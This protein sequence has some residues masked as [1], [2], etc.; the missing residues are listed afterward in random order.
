MRLSSLQVTRFGA[1][2]N[3][4]WSDLNPGLNLFFGANEAGKTTLMMFLRGMLFG[5]TKSPY[6]SL[7][8]SEPGGSLRVVDDRGREWTL[9]RSGRGKKARVLVSGPQG[10]IQGE[11]GLRPLLQDVSRPVFENIFAFSLKEL[12]ELETLKQR[13]VQHLLYSASLGLG[14]VSLK[15]VEDR[16]HKQL[17]TLFLANKQAS[18]PEINQILAELGRVRKTIQELEQQPQQYQ[19]LQAA[20]AR[21]EG[22]IQELAKK[23]TAGKKEAV[24]LDRLSQVRKV[25]EDYRLAQEVLVTLPQIDSFPE[26]GLARLEKIQA[27]LAQVEE[28]LDRWGREMGKAREEAARQGPD[29]QLLQAAATIEALAEER[30]RHK[31]RLEE[32]KQVESKCSVTRSRLEERLGRLGSQWDESRLE[33]FHPTLNWQIS[34]QE[35]QHRLETAAAAVRQAE[36]HHRLRLQTFKEKEANRDHVEQTGIIKG[37]ARAFPLGFAAL[38]LGLAMGAAVSYFWQYHRLT[39]PLAVGGLVSFLLALVNFWQLRTNHQHHL[40]ELE[41]ERQTALNSLNAAENT[42]DQE[43]QRLTRLQEEWRAWLKNA[44]LD[45]DL[46]PAGAAAFLQEIA[47]AR[48]LL[49]ELHDLARARGELEAYLEGFNTRLGEVLA[50]LGRSPVSPAQVSATLLELRQEVAGALKLQEQQRQLTQKIA[51]IDKELAGW[52]TRKENLSA[53]LDH[54][55]AAAGEQEEEG[56]R[57]RAAIFAD[58]REMS[59][60]TQELSV[61]LRLLAGDEAA[62]EQLQADLGQTT[63]EELEE[64]LRQTSLQL[65]DLKS[66]REEAFQQQGRLQNLIEGLEQ[67]DALSR[68]LLA[69]QT[70]A[71]RLR[72]AA[73]RWTVATLANHFLEQARR[74]FEAEYQPQVLRRASQYFDLLTGGRY[75]QVMAPLEGESFLVINRQG[76]HVPPERL[77][78]GTSEQLYLALRFALIQE[79]SQ[80]GRSLPLILDDILVN[81]DQPR[82]RQAIRLFQE[83]SANHQLLLFTCHPHILNLIQDTLG[84]SAPAPVMLGVEVN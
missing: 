23:E 34:I 13:E 76:S 42:W 29:Q 43:Q 66:R 71:A 49:Q 79:Y 10:T 14:P 64:R 28:Q 40:Q 4:G 47:A 73:Q 37:T 70:L 1:L 9:E 83:M 27:D 78:R 41:D 57:R 31:D 52:E 63:P 17:K 67:T 30:L 5:F 22:E 36:D 8:N 25:W 81:F 44:S 60:K 46:S 51:E 48:S 7:D 58:R 80:E 45:T 72:D 15:T 75:P 62:V 55:L 82:A 59:Q 32:L 53:A 35:Y 50:G 21:L 56:F 84:E 33:S 26:D 39:W 18:T 2:Q 11:A 65:Q 16:L 6:D 38:G 68:A 77:S 19:E 61:R 12:Q 54:L 69:E 74:R 20:R 3:R 24:W